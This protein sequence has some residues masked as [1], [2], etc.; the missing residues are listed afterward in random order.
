MLINRFKIR[1]CDVV[2]TTGVRHDT[3]VYICHKFD[4]KFQ[5]NLAVNKVIHLLR[6]D[7]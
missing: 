4:R 2:R 7:K 3:I 6:T 1:Q 5:S